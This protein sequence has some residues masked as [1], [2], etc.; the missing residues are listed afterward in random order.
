MSQDHVDEVT[1]Y[2]AGYLSKRPTTV[3]YKINLYFADGK[4]LVAIKGPE[5]VEAVEYDGKDSLQLDLPDGRALKIPGDQ[6][7]R[8]LA[9]PYFYAHLPSLEVL[10]V[11]S[12]GKIEGFVPGAVVGPNPAYVPATVEVSRVGTTERITRVDMRPASISNSWLPTDPPDAPP[13]KYEVLLYAGRDSQQHPVPYKKVIGERISYT[14]SVSPSDLRAD[15]LI[16]R[17]TVVQVGEGKDA[18]AYSFDKNKGSLEKQESDFREYLRKGRAIESRR[19]VTANSSAVPLILGCAAF[20]LAALG[21]YYFIRKR[22]S[23]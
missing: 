1:H 2:Q 18:I 10:K 14:N 22:Q 16:P 19:T 3:S 11:D 9:F 23:S 5:T 12:A 15:R 4:F 21:G 17:S 20:V 8:K 6:A 7:F 13:Y